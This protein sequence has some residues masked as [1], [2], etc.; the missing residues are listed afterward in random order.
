MGRR[1][2]ARGRGE[3]AAGRRGRGEVAAWSKLR[4]G[5]LG[6]GLVIQDLVQGDL[7]QRERWL[8]V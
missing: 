7:G 1:Q 5:W 6:V 8:G 4:A 3:G 2:E